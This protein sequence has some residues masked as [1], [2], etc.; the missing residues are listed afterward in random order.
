MLT[1]PSAFKQVCIMLYF[2]LKILLC[3][4][5]ISAVALHA[6]DLVIFHFLASCFLR[7]VLKLNARSD[8]RSVW[9]SGN[10]SEVALR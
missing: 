4:I 6:R 5:Y 2:W 9:P 7:L 8:W 1:F 10:V 3:I